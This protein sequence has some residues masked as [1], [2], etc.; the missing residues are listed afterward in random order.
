MNWALGAVAVGFV[1]L[2]FA[3]PHPR[4]PRFPGGAPGAA[5]QFLMRPAPA[6]MARLRSQLAAVNDLLAERYP[7]STLRGTTADL[8][9]LQRLLD[10]DRLRPDPTEELQCLGVALG[11]VLAS[12][13]DLHWILV[14]DRFGRDPALQYQNTSVIVYPLTMISKRMERGEPVNVKGLFEAT[15]KHL[16]RLGPKADVES[17]AG[18]T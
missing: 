12:E 14:E 9:L 10:D 7:G 13:T 6:D 4:H 16:R 15:Q 2:T 1:A 8:A 17:N 3:L 11:N 5:R 18:R